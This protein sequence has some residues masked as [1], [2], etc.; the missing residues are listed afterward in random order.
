MKVKNIE[1]TAVVVDDAGHVLGNAFEPTEE[2][3]TACDS[4]Y[5]DY[6]AHGIE[7]ELKSLNRARL[8]KGILY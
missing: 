3:L 8:L 4:D 7:L 6:F 5:T 2:V 1:N